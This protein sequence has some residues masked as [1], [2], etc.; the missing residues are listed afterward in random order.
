MLFLT[1]K[2]YLLNIIVDAFCEILSTYV[3]FT[4]ALLEY[5]SIMHGNWI[6]AVSAYDIKQEIWLKRIK[7]LQRGEIVIV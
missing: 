1:K 4:H 6:C 5:I 2:S 3:K 7:S